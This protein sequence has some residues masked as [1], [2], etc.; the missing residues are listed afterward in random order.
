MLPSKPINRKRWLIAP[1]PT[2]I[3]AGDPIF[4]N[5]LLAG[6]FAHEFL[7]KGTLCGEVCGAETVENDSG[8]PKIAK[9]INR[10]GAEKVDEKKMKRGKYK[11]YVELADL[12]KEDG[13]HLP[14]IVNPSQFAEYLEL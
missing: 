12:L 11:M 8:K 14:G 1:T 4:N 13:V 2:P 7:T 3:K 5:E 6:Y 9:P 10:S